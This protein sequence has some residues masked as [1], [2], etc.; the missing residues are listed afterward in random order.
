MREHELQYDI[1]ELPVVF[2]VLADAPAV[3]AG[4][5]AHEVF[6]QVVGDKLAENYQIDSCKAG[7]LKVKVKPGPY[8]FEIKAK[9]TEIIE[10]LRGQCPSLNIRE[11]KLACLE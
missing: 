11:I 10:E 2:R 6:M 1:H 9:A 5:Q 8:M 4:M 7:V 3:E